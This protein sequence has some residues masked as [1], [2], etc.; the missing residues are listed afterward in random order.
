VGAEIELGDGMVFAGVSALEDCLPDVPLSAADAPE[1]VREIFVA[2][3][4]VRGMCQKKIEV[5]EAVSKVVAKLLDFMGIQ[6]ASGL[7]GKAHHYRRPILGVGS[8]AP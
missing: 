7:S 8:A 3:V 4:G 2:P 6:K 5:D 1:W